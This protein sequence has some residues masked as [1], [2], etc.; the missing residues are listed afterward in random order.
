MD[1]FLAG[2]IGIMAFLYVLRGTY[3]LVPLRQ[4]K[5]TVPTNAEKPKPTS[6]TAF[7]EENHKVLTTLG[8]FTALATFVANLPD[9]PVARLLLFIFLAA[10]VILWLELWSKF[11]KH[12]STLVVWFENIISAAIMI[13]LAYWVLMYR[14][15]FLMLAG[16]GLV[17]ISVW[18][19]FRFTKLI[20]LFEIISRELTGHPKM[21]QFITIMLSWFLF[22]GSTLLG[23]WL[24][25]IIYEPMSRLSEDLW[26]SF[27]QIV[28]ALPSMQ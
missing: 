4:S 16:F 14:N 11:P 25:S 8:V 19:A 22:C 3:W 9:K 20:G 1:F 15:T 7:V 26:R 17:F 5:E 12:A 10:S 13:L 21:E 24:F 2:I 6:L 28:N 27:Y 23:G 18:L